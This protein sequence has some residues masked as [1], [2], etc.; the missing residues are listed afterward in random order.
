MCGKVLVSKAA[1]KQH[2]ESE[3]ACEQHKKKMCQDWEGVGSCGSK[4][5]SNSNS[6]SNSD[7]N[8]SNSSRKGGDWEKA[9]LQ[10][11]INEQS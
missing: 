1:L 9:Q 10:T 11:A 6:N 5:N 3:G 4:R 8:S 7:S 2:A